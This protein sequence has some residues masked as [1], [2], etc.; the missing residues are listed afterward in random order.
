MGTERDT[1]LSGDEELG[2]LYIDPLILVQYTD[3]GLRLRAEREEGRKGGV[4][5]ST[6]PQPHTQTKVLPAQPP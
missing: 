5:L 3:A 4:F 1:G 2:G 6:H